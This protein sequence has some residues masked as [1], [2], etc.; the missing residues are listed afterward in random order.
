MRVVAAV[1]AAGASRRL[2]RRK[3][4]LPFEGGT[5]LGRIASRVCQTTC[6]RVAVVLGAA[7]DSIA[8]VLADIPVEIVRND[9]WEEG[10]ASSIRCATAW[11]RGQDA[12][13]LLLSVADQPRLSVAHLD[14]LLAGFAQHGSAIGSRYA[15]VLG[16]PAIFD[17]RWFPQLDALTGEHGARGVLAIAGAESI[18][19]PDGAFDLDEPAHLPLLVSL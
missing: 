11:A 17:R 14:A 9:G 7:A 5:L 12:T 13:A 1:L 19:W 16:V 6:A 8:P 10:I 3:Q 15:G 18:D 4:L 2:G